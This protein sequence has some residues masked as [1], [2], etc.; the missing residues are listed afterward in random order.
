MRAVLA[1]E[2]GLAGGVGSVGWAGG[3]EILLEGGES[4]LGAG[5]IGGTQRVAEVL[6]LDRGG[7]TG[8]EE[9]VRTGGLDG[10]FHFLLKRGEC[11]LGHGKVAGLKRALEGEKILVTL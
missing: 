6:H 11:A 8:R 7:R 5:D 1:G 2:F 3:L 4:L 9:A 10:F